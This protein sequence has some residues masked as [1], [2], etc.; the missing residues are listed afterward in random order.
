MSYD[1]DDD[2]A[3]DDEPPE[4]EPWEDDVPDHWW[5]TEP[6]D[7]LDLL[8]EVVGDADPKD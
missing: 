1:W 5:A 8:E 3:Y 4:P 6:P 2:E 7:E